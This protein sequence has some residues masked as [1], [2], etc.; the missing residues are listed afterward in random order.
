MHS[1]LCTRSPRSV[2]IFHCSRFIPAH[3]VHNNFQACLHSYLKKNVQSCFWSGALAEPKRWRLGAVWCCY[4]WQA[5]ASVLL[6]LQA[7][8]MSKGIVLAAYLISI[9]NR[10]E[11][12]EKIKTPHWTWG[13]KQRFFWVLVHLRNENS[14]YSLRI[15]MRRIIFDGTIL[16]VLSLK[17]W[18]AIK[19]FKNRKDM[20]DFTPTGWM[21]FL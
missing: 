6:D 17:D 5:A 10:E 2:H 12:G 3:I 21:E 20:S 13:N 18:G 4:G 15:L 14:S 9:I 11:E 1:F 16:P 7:P 19:K 8:L